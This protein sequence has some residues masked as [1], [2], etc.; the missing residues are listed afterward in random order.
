[1][2]IDKGLILEVFVVGDLFR[3]HAAS[4]IRAKKGWDLSKKKHV[5]AKV[6]YILIGYSQLVSSSFLCTPDSPYTAC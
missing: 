5:T 4:A 1:M 2:K 6:A 3:H